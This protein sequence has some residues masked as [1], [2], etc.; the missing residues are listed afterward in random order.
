MKLRDQICYHERLNKMH[1]A[2]VSLWMF[3]SWHTG[4]HSRNQSWVQVQRCALRDLQWD[5]FHQ[6]KR[7]L[8]WVSKAW[9]YL[10]RI[11]QTSNTRFP[12]LQTNA[13]L[14][15]PKAWSTPVRTNT[16][17]LVLRVADWSL[18]IGKRLKPRGQTSWG[19]MRSP[20]TGR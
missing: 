2:H 10:G 12:S 18:W 14:P 17:T 3:I 13:P 11:Y 4:S 9:I 6:P 20:Q 5:G 7:A 1:T 16:W 19:F 8:G 15:C